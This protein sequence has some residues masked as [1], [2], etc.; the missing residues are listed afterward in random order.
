[1]NNLNPYTL[2]SYFSDGSNVLFFESADYKNFHSNIQ[3]IFK[4][5]YIG[6]PKILKVT[7]KLAEIWLDFQRA[8]VEFGRIAIVEYGSE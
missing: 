3:N 6:L 5:Y 4:S 1:M 8:L 7:G 2:Q